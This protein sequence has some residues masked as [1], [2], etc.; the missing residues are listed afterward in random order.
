MSRHQHRQHHHRQAGKRGNSLSEFS[1]NAT[2]SECGAPCQ[3]DQISDTAIDF[4]CPTCA[5]RDLE[6]ELSRLMSDGGIDSFDIDEA[7]FD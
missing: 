4:V 5:A 2:C 6:I 1:Y 7:A 3:P